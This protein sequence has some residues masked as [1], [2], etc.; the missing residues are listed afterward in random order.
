MTIDEAFGRVIRG[1]WLVILLC[2]LVPFGAA[3]YIGKNQPSSYEAV[4]RI[5]MGS[6]AA[7][8]NV[9]ADAT[10][11]RVLGI[12]TSPGVVRQALDKG[13]LDT[14]VA[15][16]AANNIDVRRVGVSPVMEI[17]VTDSSP[18]RATV[19]ATSLTQD[20]IEFSNVGDQPAVAQRRTEVQ[21]QLDA[22]AKQREQLVKKMPGASPN[23]VLALQAQL[24]SLTTT[25]GELER[26]LSDLD[27][28]TATT[29]RAV[30]LDPVREPTIPLPAH[31][32]QRA[33]LIA[34]LG[35]L[36]GVGLAAVLE[37]FR[38]RLPSPRAIA[39]TL[40]VPHVGYLPHRDLAPSTLGAAGP[41]A[42]R[43]AL[44]ARRYDATQL[45]LVLV[46]PREEAWA[47]SLAPLLGPQ[48][49][50]S[51]HRLVVQV[52][53]REW[54]EPGER[55]VLVV[56]SPDQVSSAA[57][58]RTRALVEALGWPVVGLV[59]YPHGHR[60]R[61]LPRPTGS[62]SRRDAAP[63]TTPE[64]AATAP[65]ARKPG[66]GRG[67]EAAGAA[68]DGGETAVS[69]WESPWDR[70]PVRVDPNRLKEAATVTAVAAV[71]TPAKAS[72]AGP[73]PDATPVAPADAGGRAVM[74]AAPRQRP[75]DDARTAPGRA[76]STP[77]GRTD[78]PDGPDGADGAD[79]TNGSHGSDATGAA[80]T[81]PVS[82]G[83]LHG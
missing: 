43:L 11:Q 7:S 26:Q 83:V 33:V 50:R 29:A 21:H 36:F 52:L 49:G 59:S 71:A 72:T 40:G 55:P 5:Q 9:Q 67:A 15:T 42:D 2:V 75:D 31:V 24:T 38:P 60:H 39:R 76:A 10:S 22:L 35:A 17:A 45:L 68:R 53:G 3:W 19:I 16:F 37:A 47:R 46:D 34:L 4:A 70:D 18:R 77:A 78:G 65:R 57:I 6:E 25:Q 27:L 62:A 58:E 61:W 82:E 79:A 73:A 8:S 54:A 20:V 12:A 66:A 30:L 64:P 28:S 14:D 44:L 23:G 1:H 63:D 41:I 48:D 51:D 74:A 13:G 80:A 32:W 81:A 56:L 69:V